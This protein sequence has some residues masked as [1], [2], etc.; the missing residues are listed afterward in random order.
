[1]YDSLDTMLLM[2]LWDEFAEA[3]PVV[4]EGNFRQVSSFFSS[5]IRDRSSRGNALQSGIPYHTRWPWH[6][7]RPHAC[8]S[9][10]VRPWPW[11]TVFQ[12][13]TL[14]VRYRLTTVRTVNAI[15]KF[16]DER[17]KVVPY[18]IAATGDKHCGAFVRCRH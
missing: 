3:L 16:P 10:W 12:R 17:F 4:K 5:I 9:V 18:N 1:M 14:H 11:Y 6:A 7:V 13:R 15:F 8:N 2:D